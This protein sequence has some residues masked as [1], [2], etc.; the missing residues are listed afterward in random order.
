M[1]AMASQITI[2]S[3]VCKQLSVQAQVK[4][5]INAPCHWPLIGEF[6]VT[7][8]F[9]AQS[10]SNAGNAYIWWRHYENELYIPRMI[11][12]V[13]DTSLALG[14]RCSQSNPAEYGRMQQVQHYGHCSIWY[15]SR[16]TFDTIV[17]YN[18]CCIKSRFL[19][20]TGHV[21]VQRQRRYRF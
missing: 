5:N 16:Q 14:H 18:F 6:T 4:G 13:S 12:S 10:A 15:H 8:E 1:S 3:I 17:F 9:P 20:M 11:P 7:G 2:L 19:S 21:I